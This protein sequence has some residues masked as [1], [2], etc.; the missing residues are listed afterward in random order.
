MR[1]PK[2]IC[3][4]NVIGH[5]LVRRKDGKQET[6]WVYDSTFGN[7]VCWVDRWHVRHRTP[8]SELKQWASEAKITG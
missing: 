4:E 3:L 5:K 7:D 1:K 6:R 8:W 2:G